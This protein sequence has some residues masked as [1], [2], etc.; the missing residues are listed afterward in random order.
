MLAWRNGRQP[1]A[2]RTGKNSRHRE[3][4]VWNILSRRLPQT[5]PRC[6]RPRR[7]YLVQVVPLD[8]WMQL[9]P[10]S[11]AVSGASSL[12]FT[13]AVDG[14]VTVPMASGRP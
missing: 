2:A 3:D 8:H 14:P 6:I 10:T 12:K 5:T 4:P 1:Q 13:V 7:R 11:V 9:G